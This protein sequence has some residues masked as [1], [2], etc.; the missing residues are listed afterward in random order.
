VTYDDGSDSTRASAAAAAADVAIVV[1]GDVMT[2][3]QDKSCIDL[4]CA[5]DA[6][7]ALYFECSGGCP[8]NGS[9]QDAL[10]SAVAAANKKTVAVLETGGPVLTPFRDQVGALVEAWYPGQRGGAAIARVLFGD[11]DPGGRLPVT[12]PQSASD[13]PTAGSVAQYPG[14]GEQVSYSEGVLVGYRW[15]DAHNITPA[16]PFGSGLSYTT[17]R[18]GDVSVEPRGS[19]GGVATVTATVTNTG[20]RT[21]VAVPQLYVGLPSPS[22]SVVQPPRQLRGYAKLTLAPNESRR[23]SFPLDERALSYWDTSK[24]AWR[25]AT[26]CYSVQV[27]ASSRDLAASGVIS[28]G[29]AT[30]GDA[31]AASAAT[32]AQSAGPA[33]PATAP[34][35]SLPN[36][37][38]ASSTVLAGTLAAT[39]LAGAVAMR[40]RGARRL[41]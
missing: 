7:N 8:P 21:G 10:V 24:S 4:N 33:T 25:I 1:V 31:A 30:C 13:L 23:V 19:A 16:F 40:R 26:G 14:L 12:F 27:G 11:T 15:Y 2:E 38:R 9:N 6:V 18:Y 29:G 28:Q 22:A 41:P 3:G 37:A 36:T 20:S 17:F 34:A 39:L 32:T 5:N 35:V